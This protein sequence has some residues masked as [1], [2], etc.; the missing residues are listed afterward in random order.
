MALKEELRKLKEKLELEHEMQFLRSVYYRIGDGG[1]KSGPYCP[2]CFDSNG[3]IV[4]LHD[5]DGSWHCMVCK[6]FPEK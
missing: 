5:W 3:K 1:N 6:T 2:T 4:N